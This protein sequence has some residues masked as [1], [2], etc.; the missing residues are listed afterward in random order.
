MFKQYQQTSE[1]G[2]QF[3]QFYEIARQHGLI[4]NKVEFF[5]IW[6]RSKNRRATLEEL[7]GNVSLSFEQVHQL[8]LTN[9]LDTKLKYALEKDIPLHRAL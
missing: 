7:S 5:S 8:L 6:R 2:I 9:N 1:S 4:F 3:E